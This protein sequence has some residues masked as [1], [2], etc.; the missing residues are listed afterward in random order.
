MF[1]T[2]S[3]ARPMIVLL[4]WNGS[5]GALF[6]SVTTTVNEL[7]ALKG[8]T[9]LSVTTVVIVFV[10]GPCDSVGVNRRASRR[11]RQG[12]TQAVGGNI[13]IAR[14]VSHNQCGQLE[15][16][17]VRLRWQDGAAVYFGDDD[18]KRIGCA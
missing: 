18:R 2:T 17:A 11:V 10:L 3:V 9:P 8:G 1:V 16:R 13:R 7:V 12:V 6:T 5:A 4:A 14:A 15:N